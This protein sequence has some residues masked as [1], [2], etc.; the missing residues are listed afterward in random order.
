MKL[1]EL[2]EI[3]PPGKTYSGK[4]PEIKYLPVSNI[5]RQE[6]DFRPEVMTVSDEVAKNMDYSEPVEVTAFHY[7]KDHSDTKPE[8][9]LIDGHHRMAAAL[10]TGKPWL[11]VEVRARN[12]KGEKLNA[13]IA[14]SREIESKIGLNEDINLS[15]STM[16]IQS[17][18]PLAQQYGLNVTLTADGP[19]EIEL[20]WI[21]RTTGSPGN[22]GKFLY[23]LIQ[24]ADRNRVTIMLAVHMGSPKLIEL[25][26]RFGF[27]MYDEEDDADP[28]MVREPK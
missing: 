28:V 21:K 7:S 2:F 15:P 23:D 18:Q 12:A 20:T 1:C 8:V 13:L 14:L 16:V 17:A 6:M 25:Y 22:G 27:E 3:Y 5:A 19:N 11:P 24:L 4:V 26:K 10:Q 9:L